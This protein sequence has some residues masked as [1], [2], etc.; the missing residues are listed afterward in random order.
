VVEVL[1]EVSS[2][3]KEAN[4]GI[5]ANT[6]KFGRSNEMLNQMKKILLDGKAALGV[7][8]MIPSVQLVEMAGK[9]G[10]DWVLIDCEHGAI[11]LETVED[12]IM[13][14]EASHITPI[15]RPPK[16]DPEIIGQY[17][18]RG[19]MGIQAPHVGSAAEAQAIIDAVKYGPIGSRSLAVGTRS[20]GYGFGISLTDYT[21]QANQELLVCVQI[22]DKDAVENLDAIA[23][24]EGIDVIF[25]GP[26]DLSQSLG[27]PG[28]YGHP[29]VKKVIDDAFSKIIAAGKIAGTAGNLEMTPT[30]LAQGV[31]YYYTHLTTLLSYSSKVFLGNLKD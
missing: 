14:A 27:H 26:S 2:K 22:E 18:D 31:Q 24:V 20:A 7:S 13:A 25:I 11:S 28:N 1:R 10:Y 15:I 5:F 23:K 21:R 3:A 30:R 17:M 16:N 19:A 8:L 12:M 9:L 29:V 6:G 4:L